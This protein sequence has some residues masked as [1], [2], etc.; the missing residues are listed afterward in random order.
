MKKDANLLLFK[1]FSAPAIF[2][3]GREEGEGGHAVFLCQQKPRLKMSRGLSLVS[4]GPLF[5][6]PPFLF[7]C[8]L[9]L[10]DESR[11]VALGSARGCLRIGCRFGTVPTAPMGTHRRPLRGKVRDAL[12]RPTGDYLSPLSRFYLSL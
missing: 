2:E 10:K 8:S 7:L 3:G 6:F 5:F 1:I 12:P 4:L 9:L 11:A